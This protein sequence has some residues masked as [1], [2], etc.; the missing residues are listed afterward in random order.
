M[1]RRYGRFTY[2]RKAA[3]YRAQMISARKRKGKDMSTGKKVA[4][5]GGVGVLAAGAAAVM[6]GRKTVSGGPQD[7]RKTV[8]PQAIEVK[9]PAGIHPKRPQVGDVIHYKRA[10]NA[11]MDMW[12]TRE[13]GQIIKLEKGTSGI[14]TKVVVKQL[15]GSDAGHVSRVAP[16]NILEHRKIRRGVSPNPKHVTDAQWISMV[17]DLQRMNR[18]G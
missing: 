1:A 18:N 13:N 11:G 5:A 17:M 12:S 2:K 4:I 8:P 14:V 10:R 9:R 7:V 15:T 6:Y 3:L 16:Y